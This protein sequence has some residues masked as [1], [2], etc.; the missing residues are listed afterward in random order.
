MSTY[1]RSLA[2]ELRALSCGAADV[3]SRPAALR[4]M[5]CADVVAARRHAFDERARSR[6]ATRIK[7]FDAGE[8]TRCSAAVLGRRSSKVVAFGNRS[9][10]AATLD[11]GASPAKIGEPWSLI[12]DADRG[13]GWRVGG[14]Q[15]VALR[16]VE[17]TLRAR[18]R[19]RAVGLPTKQAGSGI[20]QLRPGSEA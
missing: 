10:A 19:I 6:H 16:R 15:P 11:V 14:G 9:T 3:R 5:L 7:F 2:G 18:Y 13:D 17:Q 4:F 1:S 20:W 12:L 8:R